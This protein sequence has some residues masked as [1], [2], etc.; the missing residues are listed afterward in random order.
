[1]TINQH[2]HLPNLFEI[3]HPIMQH[4]LALLRERTT[5]CRL[6]KALTEEISL[7]L[8]YETLQ[9][10]PVESRTITTPLESFEGKDIQN[11]EMI[12]VPILRAGIAM[13]E[14]ISRLLP[15]AAVGHL[16]FYRHKQTL[17][18]ISY[19]FNIPPNAQKAQFL[20][21]D[22]ML[23]T[24]HTACAAITK[25]KEHGIKKIKFICIIAAPE[26]VAEIN[27]IHPDI[28]IYTA[29]LDRQLNDHAYILPGLGDA[30]DRTYGTP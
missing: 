21:C 10:L 28:S 8:A 24:G 1:M 27:K 6:F 13:A 29:G 2:P 30:G 23:A 19:Y 4:K 7:L 5:N 17:E 12:I 16:G 18:A 15:M 3:R 9:D 11:T 20:L 26:G 22:P 14:G 25:L